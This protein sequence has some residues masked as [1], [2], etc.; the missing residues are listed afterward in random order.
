MFLTL[1]DEFG[2][3]PVAVWDQ[4]WPRLRQPLAVVEGEVSRRDGTLN[5]VAMRAWLLGGL[6]GV[7]GRPD[8]R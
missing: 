3:I 2:L 8:W 6:D 1:E 7:A 5:L 4:R